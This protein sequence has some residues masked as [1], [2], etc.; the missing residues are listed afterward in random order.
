MLIRSA[1]RLIISLAV[2]SHSIAF[3]QSDMRG[4]SDHPKIPRIEGTVI[5]GYQYSEFDEGRFI[6]TI[7]GKPT[8]V[9]PTGKRT[10]II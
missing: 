4:S 7:D 10:R 8:L 2:A 1:A 3:A 5:Y 9:R 6:T